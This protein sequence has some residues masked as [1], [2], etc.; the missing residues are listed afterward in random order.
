MSA[1]YKSFT[2]VVVTHD[3]LDSVMFS[4]V[5]LARAFND[6]YI[7][8]DI[9]HNE[10][11][12]KKTDEI[13]FEKDI[14]EDFKNPHVFCEIMF[15]GETPVAYILGY[16]EDARAYFNHDMVAQCG[17]L[18]VDDAY[19]GGE[20][21]KMLLEDFYAWCKTINITLVRLDVD[22]RN[23]RAMHFYESLGFKVWAQRLF[24]TL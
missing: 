23:T 10:Y 5:K 16:T 14:R 19:R 12:H 1:T 8:E 4:L 18:F 21:G 6:F 13:D 24:T 20:I 3:N 7:E 2:K 9:P 17:S 22:I 15:D 11:K